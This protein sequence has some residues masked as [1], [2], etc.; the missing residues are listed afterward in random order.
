MVFLPD[1][2]GPVQRVAALVVAPELD[3]AAVLAALRE[4]VDPVYLPR[5]LK[6]VAALPRNATGKL[7]RGALLEALR[8][9]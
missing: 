2:E 4:V 7:P 6:R 9:A 1:S 3:E 5:P 8:G